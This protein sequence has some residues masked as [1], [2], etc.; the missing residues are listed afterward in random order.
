MQTWHMTMQ[1]SCKVNWSWSWRCHCMTEASPIRDICKTI[2][3]G[4]TEGGGGGEF[5]VE[6]KSPGDWNLN[7]LDWMLQG[8]VLGLKCYLLELYHWGQELLTVLVICE[9]SQKSP[10]DRKSLFCSS[11]QLQNWL[12]WDHC[13]M[14]IPHFLK[15]H[16]WVF[17][18]FAFASS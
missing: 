11:T 8:I 1:Q 17:G 9:V 6:F 4:M 16:D 5:L 12:I 3:V 7:E 18:I 13:S 15:C 2:A 14:K 10:E